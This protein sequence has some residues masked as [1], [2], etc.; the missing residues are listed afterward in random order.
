M[1]RMTTATL[2][3]VSLLSAGCG[4]LERDLPTEVA[5]TSRERTG[6]LRVV[7]WGVTDGLLS[8]RV[9]NDSQRVLRRAEA[10]M[11]IR[12][13][14]GVSLSAAGTLPDD[15]CCT[16][17]DVPPGKDFGLYADLGERADLVE[18][19]E[20]RFDRVSWAPPDSPS[21]PELVMDEPVLADTAGGAEVR[22]RITASEDLPALAAQAFLRGPDGEFL[23][24]VSGRF[25]CFAADRPRSV[26]VQL[27]HPVP[28]GTV[29]ESVE[30]YPM[31]GAT[32]GAA[33]SCPE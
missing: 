15:L 5:N 2:V 30:T 25:R 4:V 23:A 14:D 32:A 17:L 19:V 21:T 27:F 31:S 26:V 18:D 13:D 9:H 11:V 20:I 8:V 3:A 10:V 22:T 6:V 16:L 12:L 33:G 28:K 7:E 24:V 29:I 1:R